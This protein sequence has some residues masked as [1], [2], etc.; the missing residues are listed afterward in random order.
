MIAVGA[1]DVGSP[2]S[3]KLG[4]AILAPNAAPESG[5]DLDEFIARMGLLGQ[6]W[7]LAVGFEAPLFIPARSVAL[8]VLSRRE[9]E[10]SR[11]WSAGAGAAVTTAALG[12]ATYTLAKLREHLPA[13]QGFVDWTHRRDRAGDALFF[14]AFVTGAA[15][16]ADHAQDAEIAAKAM[17]ALLDGDQPYRS[18]ISETVVFSLLG[19]AMLRTGWTSDVAILS[20][21]CLVVR[22]DFDHWASEPGRVLPGPL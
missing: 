17:Q 16:G 1:I 9:G 3:G 10:G 19:A 2:K 13:P 5:R 4:W 7:P 12:V 11:P 20:A 18:A 8:D 15:K 14:E 21:P 22:P 6:A